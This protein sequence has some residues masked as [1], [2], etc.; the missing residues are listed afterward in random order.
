M[1]R[2]RLFTVTLLLPFMAVS[3]VANASHNYQH[4]P[5][6]ARVS[7]AYAM[8]YP[9]GYD[10]S[11]APFFRGQLGRK[12]GPISGAPTNP[13]TFGAKAQNRC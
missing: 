11:G 3:D 9:V 1:I 4:R 2:K 5:N 7:S 13:C 10:S 12:S 6:E 8:D